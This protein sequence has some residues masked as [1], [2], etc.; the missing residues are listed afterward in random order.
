MP[1][2]LQ[3]HRGKFIFAGSIVAG[4]WALG[5]WAKWKLEEINEAMDKERIAR[6]K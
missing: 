4:A 3:R 6:Q 1:S 2:F 5:K